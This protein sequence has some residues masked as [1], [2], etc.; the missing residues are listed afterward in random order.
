ME[1]DKSSSVKNTEVGDD[2]KI[3]RYAALTGSR[4]GRKTVVGD[5]S[6]VTNS[7]LADYVRVDRASLIYHSTVSR[8]TYFGQ[9]AMVFHAQIGQFCSISWGVTIGPSEHDYTKLS[10]HD[11][12]YNNQ[13][14]LR[15]RNDDPSS[16]RF[17]LPVVIGH[18]VWIG[19]NATILRGVSVGNGAVI[20]ANALVSKDVPPYAIV[21]GSPA[22][23]LK[24][25]FSPEWIKQITEMEWW[26]WPA[27]KIRAKF[28]LFNQKLSD[29][30]LDE[31]KK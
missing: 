1:I 4:L 14:E 21:V 19:A 5:W 27:E 29:E 6:R 22:K 11:F 8:Y 30:T 24:Y 17:L 25:R 18:D 15:P 2:S 7:D 16:E 26:N 12:T 28:E 31:F 13:S 10:S 20:G 9:N 3:Y 23:V